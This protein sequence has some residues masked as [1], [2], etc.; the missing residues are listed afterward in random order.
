M[1]PFSRLYFNGLIISSR[2]SKNHQKT[3]EKRYSDVQN[4]FVGIAFIADRRSIH[5]LAKVFGISVP[6]ARTRRQFDICFRWYPCDG[7]WYCYI[8]RCIAEIQSNSTISGRMDCNYCSDL[9]DGYV[10]ASKYPDQHIEIYSPI[11]SR[12]GMAI[13]MFVGCSLDNFVGL[14]EIKANMHS[15]DA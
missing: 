13:L 12:P 2:F 3:T 6:F 15:T 1:P 7:H 10:F 9:L 8:G 5:I 11:Y 4:R 14:N